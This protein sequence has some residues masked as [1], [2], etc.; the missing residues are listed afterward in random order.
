MAQHIF[1]VEFS[2]LHS[3]SN[4]AG[5]LVIPVILAM[6]GVYVCGGW[7]WNFRFIL[8]V[9]QRVH[10]FT[11]KDWKDAPRQLLEIVYPNGGDNVRDWK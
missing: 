1:V 9:L 6:N 7:G 3:V 4:G 2:T 5:T 11:A 8:A 10:G